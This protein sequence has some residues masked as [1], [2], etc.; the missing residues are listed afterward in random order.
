MKIFFIIILVLFST[1]SSAQ[2]LLHNTDSLVIK[3]TDIEFIFVQGGSFVMGSN[4]LN[5]E[6]P[7]HNV[8]V[9]SFYLS[10]YEITQQVWNIVMGYNESIHTG[11]NNCPVENVSWYDIQKFINKLSKLTGKRYRLPTEAEWEFAASGG[12][13]S[14]HYKYAGSND[15]D[16]VAWYYGNSRSMTHVI[17]QKKPNELGFY[18]MSGNVEEWC[19]DWWDYNYYSYSPV[20]NPQGPSSGT[21]KVVRGGAYDFVVDAI[22]VKG[23]SVYGVLPDL[24]GYSYGFRL[25]RDCQ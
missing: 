9:H 4:E 6:K 20:N 12:I 8:S 18:D 17:G 19:N 11:C 7:A 13:Y 1:I 24:I 16:S 10:K 15:P 2:S 25:E 21:K 3:E 14:K 5:E 23:R 22:T